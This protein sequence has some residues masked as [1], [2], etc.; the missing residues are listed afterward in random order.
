MPQN[1]DGR[2]FDHSPLFVFPSRRRQRERVPERLREARDHGGVVT[3]EVVQFDRFGDA[4]VGL[5]LACG[6]NENLLVV[7]SRVLQ[8]E[9]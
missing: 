8:V 3:R 1:L 7:L 5:R 2:L 9:K 6:A 4:V